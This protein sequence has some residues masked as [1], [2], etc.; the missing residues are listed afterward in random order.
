M[1]SFRKLM[2]LLIPC[3]VCAAGWAGTKGLISGSVFDDQSG[4]KLPGV[5]IVVVGS[6]K[7]ATTDLDGKYTIGSVEPGTYTLRISC[8]GYATKVITGATVRADE[9]LKLD[10]ALATEA[11]IG[12]EVT[13]T[14][15][16][17]ISTESAA[18][19]ERKKAATIG[20][21][22]SIEQVKRTPDATSSDALKR[23]T[24]VSLVDNK[25]VYIRGITDRY[26]ETTLD[27]ATVSSAEVGK[28]SFSFDLMPANLIENTTVVKSSTPDLPGDVTGG[29]VQM[30]TLDIP[31]RL[32][33]KISV[34]S[35]YNS[36]TTSRGILSSQ[37]G[38]TDWIGFDDG[39]REFPG[40]QED[41]L[42]LARSLK[43]TWAP[44]S[45]K[46]P[47]NGAFSLAMGDQLTFD[48]DDPSAGRLGFV[49]ALTYRNTFQRNERLIDDK[50]QS[51]YTVGSRDDYS[52]LWGGIANVTYKLAGLHKFSIKNSY[53]RTADDQVSH[54][55]MSDGSN[56]LQNQF[57]V[58]NYS[59]RSVYSGQLAGE[60]TLPALGGV[61]LLWRGAVSSSARQDP[62][63]KEASYYRSLDDPGQRFTAGY[64]KRSWSHVN[65]R[66]TSFNLDLS[67]PVDDMKFKIGILTEKKT[68][69]YL[70]RY[71]KGTADYIGG[72][73]DSLTQLSLEHVYDPQNFGAGKFLFSETSLPSDS[74]EGDQTMYAGYAMVDI[75]FEVVGNRFRLAGGA[76]LE[77]NE[78]N[79]NVPKTRT[80]DGPVTRSQLKNVDILPSMNLTYI[81]NDVTNLRVAYSHSVNRP[82]FRERAPAIY[83]DFLLNTLYGG[84]P[85][86]QRA[87]I[88]NYDVRI[89]VFPAVGELIALSYFQKQIS[90]AIEEQLLFSGTRSVVFFNSGS[91]RNSGWEL[92]LRKSLDFLGGYFSNFSINANY[93]RVESK[94][95]FTN[96]LGNSSNTY[97][98]IATRPMQGQSPY[99][100]NLS[101][102]FTEPSLG[103]SINVAYNKA[104]K[105]LQTVGFNASDIYEEPRDLVDI[106]VSQPIVGN[107]EAKLTVKNL[108]GKDRVLT[109]D[110]LLYDQTSSGTT[111]GLQLSFAL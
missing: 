94:V 83:E 79:V 42:A 63:R 34:S 26:N 29:L 92:E 30:N 55:S 105:R 37:G 25:F 23:V 110:G 93:T 10:V 22:I 27:G 98:E 46:A 73:S 8:V 4:E 1:V 32:V 95:E 5:N 12:E 84:N 60:H 104:G 86:L 48:E 7:G 87:Y 31:D 20:D 15:E 39:T 54:L 85:N 45:M 76:R 90:G 16:R 14:A 72:A 61:T 49:G 41:P 50:D 78:Q 99:M 77:N 33:G 71:F 106:A 35:S 68:T 70:I 88:R 80:T 17:I 44:R 102:L 59:Q 51:R 43:N 109:R 107:L 28:K 38:G 81:L 40:N 11:I 108:N 56:N 64:N 100:I 75:P 36:L 101:I 47:Y 58:V 18:L 13:V 2:V 21:G 19:A 6:S 91:A 53:N 67:L 24:G 103:T 111:Y 62:D 96:T 3:V 66:S 97:F 9:T 89:E 82:E 57:T 65:D 52:V 69:N 74:Y